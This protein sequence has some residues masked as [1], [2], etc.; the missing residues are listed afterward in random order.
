MAAS[1][2]QWLTWRCSH[3]GAVVYRWADQEPPLECGECGGC[4]EKEVSVHQGFS[5]ELE[6]EL[7]RL[8]LS[9]EQYGV[10]RDSMV[11]IDP[12]HKLG[13]YILKESRGVQ[14][15]PT[16]GYRGIPICVDYG[17]AKRESCRLGREFHHLVIV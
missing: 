17:V 10:S 3:C 16:L 15:G 11:I 9:M 14:F 1:F 8:I 5:Q 12:H 6:S 7:Y 2:Q 13:R 4:G